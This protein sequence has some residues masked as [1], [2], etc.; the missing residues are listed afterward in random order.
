MVQAFDLE[1]L[2]RDVFAPQPGEKVLVMVD[3]PH[4]E[5][6]RTGTLPSNDWAPKRALLYILYSPSRPRGATTPI[7]RKVERSMV[8]R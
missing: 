3:V 5:L 1:K 8:G 6:K 2:I 7:C 4:G